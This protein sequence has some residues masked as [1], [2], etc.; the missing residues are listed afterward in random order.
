MC[1]VEEHNPALGMLRPVLVSTIQKRCR[2][3]GDSPKKGHKYDQRTEKGNLAY[4][5][6][7]KELG[8]FFL[9]K[10]MLREDL[11]TRSQY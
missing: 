6:R 10:R 3:T 11:L 7:L 8:L 1:R 2:Q 9:E 4:E 5:E